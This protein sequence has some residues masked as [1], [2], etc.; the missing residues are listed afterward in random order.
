MIEAVPLLDAILLSV[1]LVVVPVASLVQV[2]FVRGVELE[3]L[4]A[5]W[6]SIVTLWLI[7]GAAWLV[8]SR[9]DGGAALGLVWIGVGPLLSW[10]VG[11]TAA[12]MGVILIFRRIGTTLGATE[13][14]LLRQLLP[15]TRR[16]KSV[17]ALLSVAAGTGEELAYRG[18]ALGLLG[19]LTGTTW[20]VA[21]TSVVFGLMH[22]YQGA[23][24]IVRTTVMGAVL[25]G[26]F[27]ASGSLWPAILAHT[28]IDILAGIVFAERLL[29]GGLSHE[30]TP[31]V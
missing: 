31:G 24:G 19:P 16:E 8:G 23:L 12:G 10:T 9:S 14:D 29:S 13:S 18:Y 20:A 5:Y 11:L 7:G 1:L 25:A 15:R 17:F 6:S 21:L 4:P 28:A 22:G 3:R 30:G 26:G 27:L 2:P